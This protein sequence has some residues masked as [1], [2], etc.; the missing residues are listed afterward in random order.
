MRQVSWRSRWSSVRSKLMGHALRGRRPAAGHLTRL[1]HQARCEASYA[2]LLTP[3]KKC[4][5]AT[6]RWQGSQAAAVEAGGV[7]GA[8]TQSGS[9]KKQAFE[10]ESMLL[11]PKE[12]R[13]VT[14]MPRVPKLSS[15]KTVASPRQRP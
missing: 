7:A 10:P 3:G 13:P 9:S 4:W 14:V 1:L 12:C 8:L 5:R 15:A 6:P 11:E 2:N